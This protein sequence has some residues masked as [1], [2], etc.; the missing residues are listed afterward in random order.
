MVIQWH[1]HSD[2]FICIEDIICFCDGFWCWKGLWVFDM[3]RLEWAGKSKIL[4]SEAWRR[5]SSRLLSAEHRQPWAIVVPG[6]FRLL[7]RL[8]VCLFACLFP[9]APERRRVRSGRSL[10]TSALT[11]NSVSKSPSLLITCPWPPLLRRWADFT[12]HS[13]RIKITAACCRLL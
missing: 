11:W 1:Y 8:F 6:S 10:C 7:I 4:L 3:H 2:T 5:C 13:R 9:G 12:S